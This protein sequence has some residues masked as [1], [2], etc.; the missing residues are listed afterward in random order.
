MTMI[1]PS[2]LGETIEYSSLHACRSTLEDPTNGTLRLTVNNATVANSTSFIRL[3]DTAATGAGANLNL[4]GGNS[5]FTKL[6]VRSGSSGTKTIANTVGT[7]GAANY[8]TNIFLDD[9]LTLFANT[10]GGNILAGSTLDLKNQTLTV[11]GTGSNYITGTL[12]NSTGSGKLTKNGTGT[13][14]LGSAGTNTYAGATTINAGELIGVTGGSCSNSA[15]TVVG[16]TNGVLVASAG[17]RWACGTLTY[18]SGTTYADFNFGANAL[19]AATAPIFVNGNLAFTVTPNLLVRASSAIP[20]GTYPLIKYTGT[21]SGTPPATALTLPTG[22]TATIV[23][24]TGNKSIDL[25]V[26]AGNTPVYW[27]VGSATWDINT[28]ANW[29]NTNGTALNYF[30]GDAVVF[31]DAFSG[32]S[33]ITVTLNSTVNPASVTVSNSTK[34]FTISGTGGIAGSIGLNKYGT[35]GLTLGTANTYTGGTVLN[36]GTATLD[37]T[38]SGAPAANIVSAS[39]ALTLG[40]STLTITGK[41]STTSAQTFNGLTLNSGASVI[42]STSGASGTANLTLAAITRN[43]TSTAKVTVPSSGNVS[44]TTGTASTVLVGGTG[45][46]PYA[47][48]TDGSGNTTDFAAKDSGNANIGAGATLAS[49]QYSSPT[50][51]GNQA[52]NAQ[53]PTAIVNFVNN[54]ANTG[55]RLSGS[56]GLGTVTGLR[57]NSNR[58]GDW[59]IDTSTAGRLLNTGAILVTPNV[60]AF[61]VLISGPGGIRQSTSGGDL[62]FMQDNTS[63]ELLMTGGAMTTGSGT[64]ATQLVKGGRGTMNVSVA[65]FY[66]GQ[67]YINEGTLAINQDGGL[68][69]VA[70]GAQANLNGGTLCGTATFT[71]DNGGTPLRPIAVGNNGGGLAAASSTTMTVDGVISGAAG[72]GPLTI[73]IGTLPGTGSGTPN[74]ALLGNGTVTLTG[75]NTYTG[76]TILQNGTLNIN[77][78]NALGGANYGGVTF[79]GGTLQYGTSLTSGS[80]LSIGN[81]IM[82]ASGGG[83]IDVNGNTVTYAG[84]IGNSGSGALTVMSSTANGVLNLQGANTFTGNTTISSGS[85]LANNSSGSATGAGNVTVASG[86]TLGGGNTA[87]TTGFISGAVTVQNGGFVAPG[88][89]VGTLSVGSLTLSSGAVCN[90]EFSSTNDQIVVTNSGGLTLNGGAFNLYTAGGVTSFTTPGTY[91]LI[92][93]SGSLSGTSTSG[94]ALDS[95]W[96]TDSASNAH[97]ANPVTGYNYHFGATGIYLTVTITQVATVGSWNVDNSGNWSVAG[98]WSGGVP[99]ANTGIA[100]DTATFAGVTTTAPRTVTL[101]A[102]ESVGAV[103][104]NQANSFTIADGGLGK[105]LTLDNKGAG[106]TIS[107]SAGTA[108]AIQTA[109][110]LNDNATAT[111]SSGKSLTVSGVVSNAPSVTKTLAVNGAGTTILSAANTYGPSAGSVGTTL[112]GGGVLQVGNNSALGAGDVSVSGSSTLKAGAALTL[113]NNIAVGSGVTATLDNN[114]DGVT[115]NGVVSGSGGVAVANTGAGTG[116]SVTLGGANTY[117]GGTTLNAGVTTISGD[118]ASGGSAGSLGV[119]PASATANNVILNGGDLLGNGIFTLNGNRG[120]GIGPI[121]GV[122]GATA[123]ID[124]ASGQTFTVNGVIASSGNTGSD[125]LNVNSL[126]S[127]PGTVVLAGA[128][129]FSGTTAISG[130]TLLLANSSALQNSTLNYNNQGGALSFGTLTA[131]TLGG[132]SGAQNLNLFNTTPAAVALTIGNNNANST[133]SGGLNDTSGTSLGSSLTKNGTAT[134]ILTGNNTYSGATVINSGTLELG[135]SGVL[136]CRSARSRGPER[137]I[138]RAAQFRPERSVWA[139]AAAARPPGR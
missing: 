98:N 92:Q 29:K 53:W 104:M 111:V 87:R 77:G 48:V 9:N 23:N 2:Y 115:L 64:S 27:A 51:S 34:S 100:G 121:S 114:S 106:A 130:G 18:S 112:S 79:N 82:F 86:G 122:T 70:T 124:A 85:L 101:D 24:N 47:Y 10:G 60:G 16:A 65:Q 59:T 138:S 127:T 12:T 62:I 71:L 36:A 28:T 6:N 14:T 26:T 105:T 90:I 83:T 93:Y 37:F 95:T 135:A 136:V 120:L 42:T 107:A 137:F 97:V 45:N 58:G 4:N 108:N 94:G 89:S 13:L 31:A 63:G 72:T 61:N 75:A 40:G 118:G 3:G 11:D 7:V 25:N 69:A 125:N 132:L 84:A 110:A 39:S 131:A 55:I 68:G 57:F 20:A 8:G 133:Y 80:D 32:T 103:T 38:A 117:A 50:A 41:A 109:V 67:R 54:S 19:S 113:A 119:V 35:A 91:N 128:N 81:G 52:Q 134:N 99:G 88:N 102:N 33:P 76:G 56:T 74:T 15:V 129:T 116:T 123:L 126:A 30:E 43:N 78:I 46:P 96:T 66:T 139:P 73:G 22:V 44:T 21:L 17:G 49:A 5:M 1:T